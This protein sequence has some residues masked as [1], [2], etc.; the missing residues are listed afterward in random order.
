MLSFFSP[1][2][3]HLQGISGFFNFLRKIIAFKLLITKMK[4]KLVL[5]F[6]S[7]QCP[8]AGGWFFQHQEQQTL[9][10]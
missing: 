10:L 8:A 7:V 3:N 1:Q 2:G 4:T 6:P 5:H 9:S